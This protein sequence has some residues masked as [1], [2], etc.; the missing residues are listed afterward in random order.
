MAG[1]QALLSVTLP[2]PHP[3]LGRILPIFILCTF[4]S[5]LVRGFPL[6]AM[7][8]NLQTGGSILSWVC[9]GGKRKAEGW[10]GKCPGGSMLE[11]REEA[12][13]A[14]A[15]ARQGAGVSQVGAV[16]VL[17]SQGVHFSF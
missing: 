4:F 16:W 7:K 2:Q 3:L 8:R 15:A 17:L 9:T 5:E 6:K 13:V 12:W 14:A 1:T 10:G 11:V